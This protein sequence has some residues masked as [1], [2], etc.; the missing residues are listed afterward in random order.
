MPTSSK[1]NR[2]SRLKELAD[3]Y[4]VEEGGLRT[5]IDN[6][7]ESGVVTQL[8]EIQDIAKA[9]AENIEALDKLFE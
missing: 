7:D 3:E 2:I 8:R 4:R 6:G 5:C 1:R 9:M